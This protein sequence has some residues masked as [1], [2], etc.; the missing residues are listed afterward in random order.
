MNR[1]RKKIKEEGK[2][3]ARN[4]GRQAILYLSF[5]WK[6][7]SILDTYQSQKCLIQVYEGLH[8]RIGFINLLTDGFSWTLRCIYGDHRVHSAYGL[9]L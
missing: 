4:D 3:L 8:S 6:V 9:L 7:G 5:A 1:A 2:S